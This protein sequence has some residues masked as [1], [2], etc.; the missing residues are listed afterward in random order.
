MYELIPP[1]R[2]SHRYRDCFKPLRCKT[3][4][5]GNSFLPLTVNEWSK[6]DS[7]IKNSDY[8]AIFLKKL[9]GFIRPAGNSVYDINYSFGV[10]LINK[11]CLGFSH[12]RE[13]K[14]RHNFDDTVNLLCSCTLE[15][16]NTEHFFLWFQSNLAAP[17]TLMN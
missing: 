6:L 13:H 5:Y 12:L 16:E 10:R 9:L 14:F 11:L 3:E 2:R 4:L 17:T 15:T 7:D 8:Y 1:L